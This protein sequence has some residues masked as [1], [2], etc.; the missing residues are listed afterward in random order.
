MERLDVAAIY[1]VEGK[2][3]VLKSHRGFSKNYIN[4]AGIVPYPKG[5]T[6]KVINYGK[7]IYVPDVDK[8]KDI[9]TAGRELGIKS[10]LIAPILSQ[11]KVLGTLHLISFQKDAFNLEEL[12]LLETVSE[13]I[14]IA[15]NN[16]Q[17]QAPEIR[18]TLRV[19]I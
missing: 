17:C 11:D 19:R 4:K 2:E 7:P 18:S 12:K 9:G 5:A 3:A 10:Y 13:E 1:L 16:A 14:G 8:D 15:I 6:W